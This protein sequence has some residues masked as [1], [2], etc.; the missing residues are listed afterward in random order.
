MAV[1]RREVAPADSRQSRPHAHPAG[2]G[3]LGLID[4]LQRERTDSRPLAR[5]QSLSRPGSGAKNQTWPGLDKESTDWLAKNLNRAANDVEKWADSPSGKS[6]PQVQ[7]I[8]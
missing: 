1:D 7:S 2:S 4:V 5:Q 6:T 8:Q 3:Q